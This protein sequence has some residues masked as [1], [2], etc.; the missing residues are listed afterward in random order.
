M[1]K[2]ILSVLTLVLVAVSANAQV[3]IGAGYANNKWTYEDKSSEFLNG[4]YVSAM[5]NSVFTDNFSMAFG[6]KFN[7]CTSKEAFFVVEGKSVETALDIPVLF[8]G[9]INLSN[10]IKA[11]IFAG[12]YAAFGVS[13]THTYEV[14]N[15]KTTIDWYDK[16][17]NTGYVYDRWNVGAIAG[18][19]F[20]FCNHYRIS[21]SYNH[22]F[23]DIDQA[24]NQECYLRTIN[25][26]I[27]Y[28][29]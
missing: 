9:S 1:R 25:A 6:L 17:N 19:H 24:D 7:Y 16:D 28:I 4:A 20:D 10:N 18:I 11:G 2:T 8:N 21:A 22:C 26:G 29:F 3:V 12:P 15:V 13:S 23:F 27:A 5:Y 14:G